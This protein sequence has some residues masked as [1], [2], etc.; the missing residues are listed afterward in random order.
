M[1]IT[2]SFQEIAAVL[3][4]AKRIGVACH[5]RPDADAI[6]S[7][8]G[9]AQSMKLA[10]KEVLLFSEDM[11]PENIKF[12]PGSDTVQQ[13]D[14]ADYSLDV[15]VALDTATKERLGV[16]TNATLKNVPVLVNIDHHGT[17][18]SYGHLNLIDTASPSCAEIVYELLTSQNFPTND[19]VR[20]NLYAGM[21]TDTGSFQYSGTTAR[22]HR[23]VAEMIDAG[24]NTSAICTQLYDHQPARRLHLLRSLLNE[25]EFSDSGRIASWK[26]T[27]E[28]LRKVEAQPGDT[29]NL[30]DVMRSVD[31]VF[32]AVIIEE[33]PDGKIRISSRSKDARVNVSKVCAE[34]G[35]GG[36]PMAAGARMSGPI[37][38]AATRFL[39]ALTNETQR[40]G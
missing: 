15:F 25:M 21:N 10:G 36:H 14:G 6:G 27:L 37:A 24:L 34:F 3:R 32:A 19:T 35:G 29:E 20:E 5:V 4:R 33:L 38:S 7:I 26:L 12:L 18:P 8:V 11:V 1:S 9:F 39:T 31:G 22:T 40:L 13:S 28:T 23:I 17:N 30:I 2:E 16:H